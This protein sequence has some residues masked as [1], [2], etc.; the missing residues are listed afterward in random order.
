[1]STLST[2]SI[3]L[4]SHG[5][6]KISESYPVKICF[7]ID[8]LDEFEGECEE[9]GML[10]SVKYQNSKACL[11]SRL[12]IVFEDLSGNYTSLKLQDLNHSDI[13]ASTKDT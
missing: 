7:L 13:T 11:S 2:L 3:L 12:C 6:P 5:Y 9:I 8:W 10:F 1:M 4:N